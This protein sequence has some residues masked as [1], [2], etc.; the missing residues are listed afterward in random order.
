[1]PANAWS[2]HD[3]STE[4]IFLLICVHVFYRCVLCMYICGL[5]MHRYA[6]MVDSVMLNHDLYYALNMNLWRSYMSYFRKSRSLKWI[7]SWNIVKPHYHKT[8]IYSEFAKILKKWQKTVNQNATFQCILRDA[9]EDNFLKVPYL[10]RGT[11]KW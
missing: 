9:S 2:N 7:W 10:L 11:V 5:I 3:S 1:M 4:F 8:C 6:L